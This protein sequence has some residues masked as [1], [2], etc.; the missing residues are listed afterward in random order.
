MACALFTDHLS[1]VDAVSASH[2]IVQHVTGTEPF[3]W[4]SNKRLAASD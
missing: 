1:G 4:R 3:Y 2:A